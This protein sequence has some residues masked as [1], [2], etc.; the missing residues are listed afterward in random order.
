MER[1]LGNER[2]LI[3]GAVLG[4]LA[5]LAP[6]VSPG[7]SWTIGPDAV[8]T[9]GDSVITRED[10]ER[11]RDALAADRRAPLSKG[12]Q[13]HVLNRLIDEELLFQRASELNL[14][15]YDPA[16]RK[17]M[18]RTLLDTISTE[19]E[20]E[21]DEAALRAFYEAHSELFTPPPELRVTRI[22]IAKSAPEAPARRDAAIAALAAGRPPEDVAAQYND[23]TA[24]AVPDGLL[25]AAKLR[26]YVGE[27]ALAA[28]L[29][30]TEGKATAPIETANGWEIYVLRERRGAA[31]PPFESVRDAVLERMRTQAGEQAL[32]QM[33]ERLRDRTAVVIDPA[34][35]E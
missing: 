12:D 26:D 30:L 15:E 24:L 4:F 2:L 10:F 7:K 23:P 19:E 14:H 13:R 20:G 8:A 16:I 27:G 35:A 6:I 21:A 3:A 5:A 22:V 9:V 25:P 32:A 28:V 31:A 18:V 17:Q 1:L 11:A 33:L 34:L 29:A